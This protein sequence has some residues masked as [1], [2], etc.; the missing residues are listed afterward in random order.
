MNPKKEALRRQLEA[1]AQT[2]MIRVQAGVIDVREGTV[3]TIGP[4]PY[5]RLDCDG[6]ALAY[7]R[8]RPRKRAVRID[9]SG[10]WV[11]PRPSPLCIPTSSGCATLLLQSWRDV[12]EAAAFL[13]ETVACTREYEL[14][15]RARGRLPSRAA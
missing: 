7:V 8:V 2:A 6:R 14:R 13:R 1:I 12:E 15:R 3:M 11:K 9:I 10:L 5:R 4:P